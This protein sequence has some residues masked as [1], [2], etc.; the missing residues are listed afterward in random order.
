MDASDKLQRRKNLSY[1]NNFF[2]LAR[3]TQAELRVMNPMFGYQNFGEMIFYT[4]Y[5]RRKGNGSKETWADAVIRVIEGVFSIRKDWY[6][7]NRIKW[8]EGFYQY[9]ARQMAFSLYTLKWAPPGRGLWAMGT[10]L[11]YKRGAMALYNCG[12]SE[13]NE[14]EDF[15]WLMDALMH[16][17][18]VGAKINKLPKP[19]GCGDSGDTFRVP[20]S[21]EGWTDSLR[22]LLD[23]YFYG[24]E[25]PIF[26]YSAIRSK[27]EPL[28]TFGGTASGPGPLID[29]HS[30]IDYVFNLYANEKWYNEILLAAD[31]TNLIGCCVVAGNVRRSAEMLQMENNN[32]FV[33]LKNYMKYPYR[34][35]FGWM[36]NNS[37]QLV[38]D[39]DEVPNL[40]GENGE[41]G[42]INM[43]NLPRGR[44]NFND[45]STADTAVGFNPCGEIPLEHREVCNVTETFPTRCLDTDDWLLACEFAAFYAS[46]VSLLPTHDP[47][48]N[49]VM[50]KNRRIGVSIV[51]YTGW[52]SVVGTTSVIRAMRRGYRRIRNV[53]RQLAEE[54]GIPS[55]L[56]VTTI[57]PGG[58]VP[59][60]AGRTPAIGYTNATYMIRRKREQKGTELADILIKAGVPYED[61]AYSDDTL[62]FEFPIYTGDHEPV[63]EVSVWE[64]AMNLVTVQR[65]WADNAVSNTLSYVEGEPIADVIGAILPHIKSVS[66]MPRKE[67]MYAQMPEEKISRDEYERR[68]S[69]IKDIDWRI[70]TSDAVGEKYCTGDKCE[71]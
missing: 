57:K 65:E 22:K 68:L 66:C 45:N 2:Y 51:D 40:I 18:G 63:D 36:S 43:K 11:M 28:K 37:V 62:C 1:V 49:A 21:R 56:R 52:R 61:D 55:A 30:N 15:C 20:D 59:K 31:I 42:F 71:I 6:I 7:K 17:V 39:F 33:N 67:G 50:L 19:C 32:T 70:Y 48:T 53:N 58:T 60:L 13:I 27:G 3:D 10:E 35:Q 34:E 29:L 41:P 44:L 54:A 12:L 4:T 46:T 69:G 26:D 14:V 8:D 47:T 25:K 9:Y 23:S 24:W 16:G 64:Q 5:S 38:N